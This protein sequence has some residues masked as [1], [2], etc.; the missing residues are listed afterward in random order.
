[1]SRPFKKR[2]KG[3]KKMKV[4]N[5]EAMK[6]IKELE[7]EKEKLVYVEENRCTVSYKEGEAKVV[8]TYNYERTREQI[9]EIE[10]E[11]RRIRFAIAK[12]NCEVKIDGFD[13]TIAEGL[14]LLAQL[15]AEHQRLARL[16]SR[17]QLTRRLTMNGILEF[18]ECL[19]SVEKAE[20][21]Q[22][23]LGRTI[24][25]LQVSID[26]ANLTNEIEI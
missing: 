4:C 18:T 25:K 8:G 21:E 24:S 23:E 14:V 11:I 19:Y 6:R 1:M 12:A 9:A 20:E 3:D 10:S 26:R 13:I 17:A 7:E 16:A 22:K 5:A 15:R 2:E